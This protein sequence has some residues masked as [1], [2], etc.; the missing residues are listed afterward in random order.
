MN[1]VVVNINRGEQFDVYLGRAGK[2]QDGYFG[3]P[4]KIG[5]DGDRAEVIRKYKRWFWK[6]VNEDQE[7]RNRVKELKGKR[8]GCFC[9][10]M[11]CHGDV[12]KAWLDRGCPIKEG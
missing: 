11:A 2:G 12:I 10:P 1:T 8:L 3:N 6:R 7:F 4:F 5:E 9:H